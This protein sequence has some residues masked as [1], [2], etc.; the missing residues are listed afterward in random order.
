[1]NDMEKPELMC[2]KCG[3][4]L[5]PHGKQKDKDNPDQFWCTGPKGH[6]YRKKEE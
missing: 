1:M 3:A 6:Y 5:K 2:P 4:P